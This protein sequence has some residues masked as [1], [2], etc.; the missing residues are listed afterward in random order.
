MTKVA[1]RGSE[2]LIAAW[3]ARVVSE[4]AIQEI[5]AALDKSPAKVDGIYVSGGESSTGVR[6]ALSYEGDDVP[7]CGNDITFWLNW[8]RDHG[9]GIVKVPRVII[10]GI[11]WPDLVR[12]EL[13]FGE[14]G[15]EVPS[16]APTVGR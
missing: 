6:V 4:A 13:D 3:K 11:P 5:A 7:R 2:K 8:L 1:K 10:N 9:G 12:L 14:V 16:I 15:S